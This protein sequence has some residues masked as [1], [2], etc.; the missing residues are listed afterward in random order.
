MKTFVGIGIGLVCSVLAAV[1]VMASRGHKPLSYSQV[2][3]AEIMGAPILY[4]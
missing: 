4:I 2:W 1:P 3:A